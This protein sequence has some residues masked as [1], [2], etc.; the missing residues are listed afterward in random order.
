MEILRKLKEISKEFGGI[1]S[2]KSEV[3]IK[4]G[5]ISKEARHGTIYL[6]VC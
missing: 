5:L 6:D 3:D 2:T 4:N 1:L